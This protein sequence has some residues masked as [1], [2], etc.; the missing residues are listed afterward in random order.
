MKKRILSM[1]LT[2][3]MAAGMLSG[4]CLTAS[5][6]DGT[7]TDSGNTDVGGG[8]DTGSG[9]TGTGGASGTEGDGTVVSY[10]VPVYENGKIKFDENNDVVFE[11]K[12][13]TDY[14]V[15]EGIAYLSSRLSTRNEMATYGEAD[16]TTWYVA[17]S[18]VELKNFVIIQGDV[19]L[20][21]CDEAS[22]N[23]SYGLIVTEGNS[24]TIYGQENGTGTLI[25]GGVSYDA[26]SP[27][28]DFY[29]AAIGGC[30]IDDGGV[31]MT[32]CGTVTINGGKIT[33]T[34]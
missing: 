21:L 15:V 16:T 1:L 31:A 12:T 11:T 13:V 4:I 3:V 22:I 17:N 32:N 29:S 7:G 20:I 10:L 18:N 30:D 19:H 28:E 25:A 23:S 9:G 33:A 6:S 26:Y 8:T 2:I 34:G 14:T 27:T 24:L 5:A